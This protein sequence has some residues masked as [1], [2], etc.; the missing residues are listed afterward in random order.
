MKDNANCERFKKHS[1]L[2]LNHPR[3]QRKQ[4]KQRTPKK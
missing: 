3:K 4:R 1:T 2:R